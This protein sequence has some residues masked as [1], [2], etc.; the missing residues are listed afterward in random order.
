MDDPSSPSAINSPKGRGRG[1]GRGHG[2][3]RG[4]GRG[5]GQRPQQRGDSSQTQAQPQIQPQPTPQVPFEAAQ[6]NPGQ[7]PQNRGKDRRDDIGSYN[8]RA[9]STETEKSSTQEPSKTESGESQSRRKRALETLTKGHS[10]L[11]SRMI[12]MLMGNNYECMVCVEKIGRAA[13]VWSCKSCYHL[14]HIKCIKD[15]RKS[16]VTENG[17]WKCPGCRFNYTQ[18][19]KVT[20]FCGK[21]SHE[22][23]SNFS[24]NSFTLPHR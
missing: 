6:T 4:R 14:F 11:T 17:S 3:G 21:L 9:Q 5:R 23:M 7:R 12:T 16:S 2:R 24:F 22:E 18:A 13:A 20:C 15:W 10:E 19:P 8:S 1:R